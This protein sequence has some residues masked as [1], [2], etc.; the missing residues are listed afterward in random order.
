ML[1]N[2]ADCLMPRVARSDLPPDMCDFLET[3][4]AGRFYEDLATLWGIDGERS[5]VKTLAFRVILFGSTRPANPLWVA[6]RSKWP[7]VA[8]FL[9][10]AKSQDYAVPARASQRLE[11]ALMIGRVAARL[12]TEYPDTPIWTIH[13]SIMVAPKAAATVEQTIEDVFAGHGL[14]PRVKVKSA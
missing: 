12:M 2:S 9:E 3:C 5:K 11:S 4:E 8:A 6:F 14:Q 7:T 13:D 1:H 10:L